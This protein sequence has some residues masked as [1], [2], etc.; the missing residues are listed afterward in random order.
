MDNPLQQFLQPPR[1]ILDYSNDYAKADA[2]KNQNA[3]QS[4]SLQQAANVQQQ[5]NALRDLVQSGQIDFND[6]IGLQKAVTV[7]PDVAPAL[8]KSIQDQKTSAALAAKDTAQA[9]NFNASTGKSNQETQI[10]SHQQHLQAL[11]MV[12]SPQDAVQW[13]VDGVKSGALP[14]QGLPQALQALQDASA[15]PVGVAKWTGG[16]QQSGIAMQQQLEMTA[17]KPTEVRLGNTVK[18]IDMNPRS[19]TFGTEVVPTQ[20]IGTSPDTIANN[21]TSIATN[22]A[23]NATSRQNNQA[24]INKDL[25]VAGMNPDGSVSP[26]QESMAQLIANGKQA[27]PSGMAAA[28]PGVAALMARVAQINPDYDATTY[29]AKTAAARG[30]ASGNQGN[31]LRS[32]STANEHLGQLDALGDALDN[33]NTPIINSIGKA[34]GI[35]TGA[36]PAQ[37]F[38]AV[39]GVVAQEVVKAIVA[40][41]GSAGERDEAA[42]AFNSA[43]SPAQLKQTIAAYRTVMSAQQANLIEQRRAAGLPDSTLPNYG[44]ASAPARFTITHINGKPQ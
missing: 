24:N 39:K 6:P 44:G 26:N 18:T 38:N 13:M 42:K 36:A 27:A 17:A 34:Y 7:A 29:A 31:A 9:G 3:M 43:S 15:T 4:L 10:A 35:Q 2:L 14:Q 33:G 25:T 1:S 22:A 12:N 20:A 40:G 23:T 37:V 16:V 5:R 11:S 21:Q 30:F 32:I 8:A 28:R 41:G 19:Q